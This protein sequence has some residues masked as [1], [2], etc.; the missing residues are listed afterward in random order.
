MQDVKPLCFVE[1]QKNAQRLTATDK[2]AADLGLGA[3]LT[4]A[5]ARARIPGLRVVDADPKAD[6]RWLA[7]LAL[8]ADR[9]TPLVARDKRDG[10]ILDITGCAHLF[11]GEAGL[12]SDLHARLAP[13]ATEA[14]TVIADTP[15][16]AAA[17]AR[18]APRTSLAPGSDRNRD[19]QAVAPLPI[20]A[21]DAPPET[22]RALTRAGLTTLGALAARPRGPI[23]ARFGPDLLA[24]LDRLLGRIDT[25]IA[26]LRP[27]PVLY[28]DQRFAEPL[29]GS[30]PALA[31]LDLLLREIAAQ[32]GRTGQGGQ[33][34]SALFFQTDGGT[35]RIDVAT[36]RPTRDAALLA[37]LFRERHA[38]LKTTRDHAEGYDQLRLMV[39]AAEPLADLQFHI[40]RTARETQAVTDLKDRLIARFGAPSV[41]HF[42][43]EDTHMPE[44]AA[45]LIPALDL[46]K[47]TPK[48]HAPDT[49]NPDRTPARP[50]HLFMPPEPIEAVAEI[51]DGPPLRFR[52]R[53]AL[54]DIA[55]AEGPERI[56]PEWW[57]S[58]P[59]TTLTRDYYRIEDKDGRRFWVFREGLYG[60]ETDHPKW[61]LH[62]LFP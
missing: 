1:R 58:P 56:A 32:L 14:R 9:Y 26:P 4:L 12:L 61:F 30:E 37:R 27:A 15:D 49:L 11:G 47:T 7:K 33:R 36:V 20:A 19:E 42:A 18:F 13:V 22:V 28:A 55:R 53:K 29:G 34:F 62:G 6:A 54:H 8:A 38:I 41:L 59:R 5:D 57:L 31:A 50:T 43:A 10:L 23:E 25:G 39:T 45:F 17:L 44:R 60:D 52:W 3:G 2:R 16:A 48:N 46:D 40:D 51:P 21:L 24:R 35:T